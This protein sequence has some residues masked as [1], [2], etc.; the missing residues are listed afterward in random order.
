[1]LGNLHVDWI[2]PIKNKTDF[3]SRVPQH[4]AKMWAT[5]GAVAYIYIYIYIHVLFKAQLGELFL[6][7]LICSLFPSIF[8]KTG[9]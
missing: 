1:M 9:T 3:Q 7:I 5:E 8:G 4:M 2:I 6:D